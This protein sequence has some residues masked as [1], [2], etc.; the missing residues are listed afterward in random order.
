MTDLEQAKL[1]PKKMQILFFFFNLYLHLILYCET[2]QFHVKVKSILGK[3]E[4]HK[5]FEQGITEGITQGITKGITQV[6]T[7]IFAEGIVERARS[8]FPDILNFQD[9][10]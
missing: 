9:N 10:K 8:F 5:Y 1:T 2:T 7:E 3:I 4:D 6:I